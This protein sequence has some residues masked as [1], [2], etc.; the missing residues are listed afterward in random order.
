MR[1]GS[2]NPLWLYFYNARYYDPAPEYWRALGRFVQ[3]DTVVPNPGDPVA[4]DRYAYSSGNPVKY[5][6]PTGHISDCSLVAECESILIPGARFNPAPVD[7]FNNGSGYLYRDSRKSGHLGED[8]SEVEGEKLVAIGNGTV[9]ATG[10]CTYSSNCVYDGDIR[11]DST[12]WGLGNMLIVEVPYSSLTEEMR[13]VAGLKN[14]E[15]LFFEYAHL[16]N[17]TTLNPGDTV[18][19]GQVVGFVGNTGNSSGS[20]L[21]FEVRK[22][23]TYALSP[24]SYAANREKYKGLETL[25]PSDF[26]SAYDP[27]YFVPTTPINPNAY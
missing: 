5:I 19:P 8:Y 12:Q 3:A 17:P 22:G 26:E 11:N 15:S 24:G 23:P 27:F 2:S 4:W 16:K 9:V 18:T 25:N 13:S 6:D 7:D 1:T 14:G 21:H 20:H 10:S